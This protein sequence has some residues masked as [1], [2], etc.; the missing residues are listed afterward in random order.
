VVGYLK[1]T[2]SSQSPEQFLAK[3]QQNMLSRYRMAA[4]EI[5][6]EEKA[7]EQPAT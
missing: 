5:L 2:G 7:G 3:L 1:E 4:E 6:R